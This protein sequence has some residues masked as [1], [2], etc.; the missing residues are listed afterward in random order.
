M[1]DL[2]LKSLYRDGK[3]HKRHI[4]RGGNLTQSDNK[5]K[6]I[7]TNSLC[8]QPNGSAKVELGE[9][10]D[11]NNCN[12]CQRGFKTDRG[13]KTHERFCSSKFEDIIDS[14]LAET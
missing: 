4:P 6:Q 3:S 14:K 5:L 1:K 12:N 9:E 13:W 7:E 11:F 10:S 8:T 2:G